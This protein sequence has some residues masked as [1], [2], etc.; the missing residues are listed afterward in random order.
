MFPSGNRAR[1]KEARRLL[2]A[3]K[4]SMEAGYQIFRSRGFGLVIQ[5]RTCM[6]QEILVL[7]PPVPYE[8]GVIDQEV[9]GWILVAEVT[10]LADLKS[11]CRI[12]SAFLPLLL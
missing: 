10:N 8:L 5:V 4:I 1:D 12:P 2:S 6:R 11:D 9:A 3:P 7:L